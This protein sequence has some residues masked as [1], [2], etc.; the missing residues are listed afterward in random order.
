MALPFFRLLK[1]SW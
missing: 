1:V